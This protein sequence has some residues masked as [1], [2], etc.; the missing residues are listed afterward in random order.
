MSSYGCSN[1]EGR[2]QLDKKIIMTVTLD[3]AKNA[4]IIQNKLHKIEAIVIMSLTPLVTSTVV[5][6]VAMNY[7]C[8]NHGGGIFKEL[9]FLS[10]VCNYCQLGHSNLT[11]MM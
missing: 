10:E 4:I 5:F 6:A 1:Q 3:V 9:I 11:S 2:H 7:N 8:G